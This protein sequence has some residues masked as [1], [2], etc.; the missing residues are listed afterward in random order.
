MAEAAGWSM[1]PRRDRRADPTDRMDADLE[2][3]GNR[4]AAAATVE[5]ADT[6]L[7]EVA[8]A[9]GDGEAALRYLAAYDAAHARRLESQ[10]ALATA[11]Q[12]FS[13][14]WGDSRL[15]SNPSSAQ[16]RATAYKERAQRAWRYGQAYALAGR[17]RE[18]AASLLDAVAIIESLRGLIRPEDRV[19][20]FGRHTS[21]YAALV[22][23]LL[24]CSRTDES[25][26][27]PWSIA[28]SRR[29]RWRFTTRRR[30]GRVC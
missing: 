17:P 23:S 2:R 27:C 26:R 14:A 3:A 30:R 29:P 28:A 21:P 1:E 8:V 12:R 22:D 11:M 6:A 25:P 7:V 4:M 9:R 19:A 10:R 18:A 13:S 5:I 20:F 15:S 24:G 16:M